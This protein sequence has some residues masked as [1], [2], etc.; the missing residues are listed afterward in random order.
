[1]PGG[2]EGRRE[3]PLLLPIPILLGGNPG[4]GPVRVKRPRCSRR[5]G[6]TWPYSDFAEPTSRPNPVRHIASPDGIHRRRFLQDAA[7]LGGAVFATANLV[8]ILS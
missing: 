7:H 4:H 2:V 3:H 6:C 5:T 8:T 1:M